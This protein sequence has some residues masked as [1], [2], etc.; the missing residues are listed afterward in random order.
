M[1]IVCIGGGPAGLYFG[2]LMKKLHPDHVVT[3]VERNRPY[4][5]FGWGVVFS[6]A[7]M[8]SM[9]AWDPETAAEIQDAF[10]HWDD[11]EVWFKGTRQ[12]TTGHGFVGIGRKK[13]LNILQARCER[14]G[15]E[16]A[17]ERDVDSDLEFPDADLIIASDGFNSKIRNRQPEMFQPDLVTR[18][19]R[20]IWL[21]TRKLYDAFTFDFRRTE[22]G[23]FQAHIYKFDDQTSTFIVETTEEAYEAHGLGA[24][25]QDG[26]IAFCETL[27]AEVLD[28]AKLMTNARH[29]RGS[30]WLNF[31]RLICGR[32]S[33][34][35]GKSHVVLVG[36]AAHTAHFAIGS[37]TKLAIDDAIELTRQFEIHGHRAEAIP[38]VLADY[39]EV[40]RVDVARI[41]NAARNAMEWFEVVGRRYAD[42]LEPEQ[43]MYSMLTRSQRISHEN[44]RLRD[45][46]WL[47]NYE[48]WFARGAGLNVPD[49]GRAPPPMFTPY[50]V[51]GV[52]LANRIVVSPMAMYSA[53]DGEPNDFHLV[54]LGAR[55]MGGAA[56]VFGEMTCVSPDARITPG[57]LG[58]WNERQAAGWKRMV[59]FVHANS[60]AKFGIQL[61]HAGRKGS[62][63]VAWEGIDRPLES[64]NWPLISASALPYLKDSQIPKAMDRADIARVTQDF[65]RATEFAAG[66]GADWL[67]LH[68][69][70]GYLL[71]S[72]LS[73]LTNLR[74]DEYGGRHENRARFPLD[75]F[76]A[77]RAIWPAEKPI[78]VRLSCHDWTEG[79]NIPED[80]AIFADLFKQA[81]ADLIDCSSG[82]VSKE[83]KPVYGRLFQTPFSDKIRNEISIPTIAVGAISEAD[84]A[85]SIIAAGRAD[86]CAV[87]RPHL[88]D[89]AWILHEA[90]KIGLTDIPWPKQYRM[91]KMQYETNLARAAAQPVVK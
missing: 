63:K 73:P 81:G 40:R 14:L 82:Q 83:E 61:G 34:F 49:A 36:D 79:G 31:Q 26:S 51:R 28:G 48:R 19:N 30:A 56:L 2:L 3:V 43:F 75:V 54:H 25:G 46:D 23:W 20:Y 64:G 88:A 57:C 62:T 70:H 66:T 89:A 59:D 67:E 15:V 85:N 39:E 16:L 29:L 9:K 44:L 91:A 52:T 55:A 17:F 47:E 41:Q 5:T 76:R 24:L 77:I 69:A 68:C 37:G 6:D 74:T 80:A 8:D 78:S 22:H 27:F 18:P 72:F 10:N 50:V 60:G 35:N 1:R 13:L 38:A 42:T 32:W 65:V 84:H 33:H 21:G 45:K 87:A 12:R 7:T 4:D 53:V 11:I 86:L 58:L 71:S 90:A